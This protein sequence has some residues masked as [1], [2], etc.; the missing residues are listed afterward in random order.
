MS[1]QITQIS[2][3]SSIL[4]G[5]SKALYD[6]DIQVASEL[7][8][9]RAR[10]QSLEVAKANTITITKNLI[11]ENRAQDTSLINLGRAVTEKQA[12]IDWLKA[13]VAS[14][15]AKNAAQDASIKDLHDWVN[16]I[17]GRLSGQVTALGQGQ[18]SS[19][20]L[21]GLGTGLGISLPLLAV[22]GAALLLLTRR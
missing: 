20:I 11:E 8:T 5:F 9:I 21:G 22:G 18:G 13:K 1:Y 12:Q 15:D 7:S 10:L 17:N 4:A 3:L 2:G 6:L 14:L 16:E 19:N